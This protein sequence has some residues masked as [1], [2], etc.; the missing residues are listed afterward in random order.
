M[1]QE[2]GG[3]LIFIEKCQEKWGGGGGGTCEGG[4]CGRVKEGRFVSLRF[5]LF[6]SVWGSQDTHMLGKTAREVSLSHPFLCAR[7]ASKNSLESMRSGG[8]IPPSKGVSQQYWHDT[9]SKQAKWVRYPPSAIL[10]RKGIARYGGGI[11][12]WAV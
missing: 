1:R 4:G 11:S 6:C 2:T 5:P 3:G 9:L 8:A 10:S 7:I 12:H